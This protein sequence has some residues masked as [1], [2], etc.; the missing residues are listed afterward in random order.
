MSTFTRNAITGYSMWHGTICCRGGVLEHACCGSVQLRP[1]ATV[2]HE[3][4]LLLVKNLDLK[5]NYAFSFVEKN[6]KK[7]FLL[8]LM[9]CGLAK[10]SQ[11][12]WQRKCDE[13]GN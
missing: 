6:K 2:I 8:M 5:M 9:S 3:T 11:L 4:K 12:K 10:K 1:R 7:S 13:R